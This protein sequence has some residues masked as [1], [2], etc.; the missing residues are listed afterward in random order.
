MVSRLCMW[1]EGGA[2]GLKKAIQKHA[3]VPARDIS[4]D[5]KREWSQERG[6]HSRQK[7]HCVQ[8]PGCICW[9]GSEECEGIV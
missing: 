9:M 2:L 4:Q 1:P 5:S 7:D 8:E 6:K 3:E